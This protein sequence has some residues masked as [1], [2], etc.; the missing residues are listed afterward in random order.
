MLIWFWLAN[1]FSDGA[2]DPLPY[3]PLLNPLELGL[4]LSLIG[5]FIWTRNQLPQLGVTEHHAQRMAQ[6]AAGASLF[7]LLSAMVT[8]S[9]HHWGGVPWD[10]NDLLE[11]MQ[12]QAG[13]SIVWTLMALA[14]MIGGHVRGRREVWIAGAVLIGVVVAKLFFVEL[15]NRGGMARIV[16]FIGVGVLLLVV[17]YFAPLPPKIPAT[18]KEGSLNPEPNTP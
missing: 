15:S 5:V 9:A 18:S 10:I 4:L 11:S 7:M 14:L 8:R 13:L 6:V 17:G 2:A 3:I 12:V 16:S 1:A